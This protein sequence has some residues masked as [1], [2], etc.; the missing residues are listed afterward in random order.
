MPVDIQ[1]A[2]EDSSRLWSNTEAISILDAALLLAGQDPLLW[3]QYDLKKREGYADEQIFRHSVNDLPHGATK[4]KFGFYFSSLSNAV[5]RSEIAHHLVCSHSPVVVLSMAAMEKGAKTGWDGTEFNVQLETD[6][7]RTTVA[8]ADL[9]TW[10]KATKAEPNFFLDQDWSQPG[11]LNPEHPYYS[12]KLSAAVLAWR[13]ITQNF[14]K[15]KN[16][17]PSVALRRWLIKNKSELGLNNKVTDT[18]KDVFYEIAGFANWDTK[19][20]PQKT[21]TKKRA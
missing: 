19:R 3:R 17:K 18:R 5:T 4:A 16:L 21:P 8:V 10:L 20:G 14:E 15:T 11:Y 9:R 1:W 6:W 7:G 2:Y 13:A 12:R